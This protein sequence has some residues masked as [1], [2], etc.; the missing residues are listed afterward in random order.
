MIKKTRAKCLTEE[1][2]NEIKR[3]NLEGWSTKQIVVQL[4]ITVH[5]GYRAIKTLGLTSNKG[6][7]DITPME[8]QEIRKLYLE[9]LTIQ[10]ITNRYNGRFNES[11]INL[12]VKD[13]TRPN[14]VQSILDHNYFENI[15]TEH[16]AY[17]LG[18]ISADGCIRKD[19]KK[20]KN[21]GWTLRLEL[22]INDK[23]ILEE[24]VKDLNSTAKIGEYKQER[25]GFKTKHNCYVTF[26]SKK[27]CQDL[28][29]LGVIPNKTFLM[30]E[31]PKVPENLKHHFIR[32]YFDGNGTIYKDTKNANQPRSG[33]C[34]T[35]D[36][37]NSTQKEI[38]SA[39]DILPKKVYKDPNSN[40]CH[41]TY[42]VR[43]TKKLCEWIYKDATIYLKRKHDIYKNYT[44]FI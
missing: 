27:L 35:Y 13:I 32:G 31:L 21:G 38:S 44:K 43:E 7:V 30:K 18:F 19:D 34:G 33:F 3:L 17:W 1:Q 4:G 2:L 6:R 42:G 20:G 29:K 8:K 37:I 15:D 23:Y 25:T 5:Q 12:L 11:F 14:G 24:L 36:I 28:I 16:K 26:Y 39:T 10:Q 22:K 41:I 40:S 9:G